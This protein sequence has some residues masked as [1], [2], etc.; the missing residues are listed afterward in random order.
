MA[1]KSEAGPRTAFMMSWEIDFAFTV[2]VAPAEVFS[3]ASRRISRRYIDGYRM[4][5]SRIGSSQP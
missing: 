2:R 3:V 4:V 5:A 1:M